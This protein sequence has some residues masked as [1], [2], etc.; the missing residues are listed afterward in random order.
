MCLINYNKILIQGILQLY[1]VD[2]DSSL[3]PESTAGLEDLDIILIPFSL[4][5]RVGW[6]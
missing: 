5:T 3:R 1:V 2:I 6:S 4:Q